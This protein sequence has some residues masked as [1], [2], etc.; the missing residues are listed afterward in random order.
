M[1]LNPPGIDQTVSPSWT[2]WGALCPLYCDDLGIYVLNTV[3]SPTHNFVYLLVFLLKIINS[4]ILTFASSFTFVLTSP[5]NLLLRSL[6]SRKTVDFCSSLRTPIHHLTTWTSRPPDA[7]SAATLLVLLLDTAG[8]QTQRDAQHRY[9]LQQ[10]RLVRLLAQELHR[11]LG[12]GELRVLAS[13][14][15]RHGRLR[16]RPL[17]VH[18]RSGLCA[19]R[20]L[21]RA[22]P[23]ATRVLAATP[24][25]R[26]EESSSGSLYVSK[27]LST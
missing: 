4:L 9:L 16:P 7:S 23:S 11:P 2:L 27:V 6:L 21:L 10:R 3:V 1:V 8:S 15:R 18:Q 20:L 24:E 22:G 19:L 17:P 12:P 14:L 13:P 25:V 5:I 26:S